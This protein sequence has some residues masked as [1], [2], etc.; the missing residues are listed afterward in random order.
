MPARVVGLDGEMTCSDLARGGRLIQI[1]V[2]VG[3]EREQRFTSFVGWPENEYVT[4]PKAMR[5]HGISDKAIATASPAPEVD[6]RLRAFLLANGADPRKKTIEPV[7]WNV[8]G[9]DMPFVR[10][11][12]P[13]SAELIS[14]RGVDLNAVCRTLDGILEFEGSRPS[15]SGWKRLAKRAAEQVLTGYGIDEEWHDAGFD[16]AAALAAWQWLRAVIDRSVR[17]TCA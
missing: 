16:A 13:R 11:A 3:L 8:V 1:G 15:T 9:F 6:G 12:L 4:D 5:V 17:D 2:A 14:R 7:G 10:D